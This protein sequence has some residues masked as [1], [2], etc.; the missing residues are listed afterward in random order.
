MRRYMSTQRPRV[1]GVPQRVEGRKKDGTAVPISLTVSRI[2]S[3][4]EVCFLAVI[5]PAAP[6]DAARA[7]CDPATGLVRAATPALAELLAHPSADAL[8]ATLRGGAVSLPALLGL[9][10]GSPSAALV[11]ASLAEAAAAASQQQRSAKAAPA[12][13]RVVFVRDAA[14][15]RAPVAAEFAV[16]PAAEQAEMRVPVSSEPVVSVRLTRRGRLRMAAAAAPHD[17]LR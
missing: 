2:E 1:L 4:G 5:R 13:D 14:G 7:L 9:D 17:T 8:A 15:R 6:A 3:G 16:A 10:P 12:V 11:L